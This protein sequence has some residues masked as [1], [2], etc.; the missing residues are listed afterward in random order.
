MQI[1]AKSMSGWEVVT[2]LSS[3]ERLFDIRS[4]ICINQALFEGRQTLIMSTDI[5]H[6]YNQC[7]RMKVYSRDRALR[8][9][10]LRHQGLFDPRR[11]G[12]EGTAWQLTAERIMSTWHQSCLLQYC[13]LQFQEKE[14]GIVVSELPFRNNIS[15]IS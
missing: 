12:L 2:A 4:G 7:S 3:L 6:E 1:G 9:P 11:L 13:N 5:D 8:T 15:S 14:G 10:P